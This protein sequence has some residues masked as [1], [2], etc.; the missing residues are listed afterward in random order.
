MWGDHCPTRQGTGILPKARLCSWGAGSLETEPEP[1][2][3][4]EGHA[5]YLSHGVG[6]LSPSPSSFPSGIQLPWEALESH[7][8]GQGRMSKPPRPPVGTGGKIGTPWGLEMQHRGVL[9][10]STSCPALP[11]GV[12]GPQV[13]ASR[14]A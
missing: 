6:T 12:D 7:S 2:F 5:T 10:R 13:P 9:S 8:P 1:G 3:R 4:K 14:E 11:R